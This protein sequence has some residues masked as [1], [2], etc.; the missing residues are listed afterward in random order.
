MAKEY[1]RMKKVFCDEC[2]AEITESTPAVQTKVT[3]K[4]LGTVGVEIK[5]TQEGK[6]RFGNDVCEACVYACALIAAQDDATA[7]EEAATAGASV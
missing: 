4:S 7:R 2:E 5:L 3:T 1:T 6:R